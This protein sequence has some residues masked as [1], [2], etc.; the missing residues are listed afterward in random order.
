MKR[1]KTN[2]EERKRL[3]L[4]TETIRQLR[5]LELAQVYGGR[6]CTYNTAVCTATSTC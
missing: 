4:S 2:L 5:E 3:K 1:L 6:A